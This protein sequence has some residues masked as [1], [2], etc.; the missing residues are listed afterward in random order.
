M[1]DTKKR[2]L[3]SAKSFFYGTLLSRFGGLFRDMAMAALFGSGPKIASFMIAF[4]FAHLFR[5]LLGESTMNL[6]FI[7]HFESLRKEDEKRSIGFFRDFFFSLSLILIL[8]IVVVQ[9]LLTLFPGGEMAEAFR[10]T[11]LILPA[12]FF[13]CLY[14]LSGSF[15]QCYRY[16]FI[17]AFAPVLFNAIWIVSLFF[18]ND[19]ASLCIVIVFGMLVQWLLP[20]YQT[21]RIVFKHIS[22]KEW[23]QPKI[24]SPEVKRLFKSIG[25]AMIGISAIQINTASDAF[26]A[27]FAD[28]S[29]PAY[30]WYAMRLQQVPIALFGIALAG[31]VLP[32]L[33]RAV[34]DNDTTRFRLFFSDAVKKSWALMFSSLV[35][36]L[37]ISDVVINLLYGRG[38]FTHDA[39]IHTSYCLHGYAFALPLVSLI[40]IFSNSFYAIKDYKI[41]TIAAIISVLANFLFNSL[42]VFV[43]HWKAYSIAIATSLSAL[44]Q[45]AILYAALARKAKSMLFSKEELISFLKVFISATLAGIAAYGLKSLYFST[46]PTHFVGQ[47]RDFSI[48]VTSF[49]A[50]LFFMAKLLKAEDLLDI[51]DISIGKRRP[52]KQNIS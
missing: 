4:R 50:V 25:F 39:L 51:I 6:G 45:A 15:L 8:C 22:L 44:V 18:I 13:V 46:L 11:K 27:H 36:I 52:Q 43:F 40:L 21:Q 5:R 10:L 17:P 33:V 9:V 38:A 1:Q 41:P 7:P 24:F 34:K 47:I 16:F 2:I 37:A 14:G 3:F 32:P 19:F 12:L 42:F 23:F 31:A 30:L 28:K 20:F 29:G 26:F 48:L 35:G 49:L